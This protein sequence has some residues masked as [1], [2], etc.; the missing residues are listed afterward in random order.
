LLLLKE[1]RDDT[2]QTILLKH[3]SPIAWQHIN[4]YGRYEFTKSPELI[5]M[6]AIIQELATL[7]VKPNPAV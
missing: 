1:V 6:D 3:V 2:Q 4:F 5:N 7:P